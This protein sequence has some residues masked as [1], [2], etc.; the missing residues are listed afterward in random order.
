M[1]L[2]FHTATEAAMKDRR[3]AAIALTRSGISLARR[4]GDMLEGLDIYAMPSLCSEPEKPIDRPIAELTGEIL[5][6]Y[7]TLIFITA[8]GIAVRAIAPHIR[9]K[10]SDPAV[11]VMD[12]Q[13]SFVIS[14]LSGHLGGANDEA[15]LVESLTGAKAVI[16]TASDVGGRMAVDTLAKRLGCEIDCLEDAKRITALMVNGEKVAIDCRHSMDMDIP[17][18]MV[19]YGETCD[20]A[21]IIRITNRIPK[22][23]ELPCAHLIEKTTVIGLGCRRGTCAKAI[24]NIIDEELER[25]GIDNRSI[26]K[27]ASIDIKRDEAGILEA[28]ENYGSQAC[29]IAKERILAV[30][31]DFAESGFVRASVGVGGVCEP[32][33]FIASGGGSMLLGKTARCGV[34]IS[35]WEEV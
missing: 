4:L 26:K 17:E 34:A 20:A 33:G 27:L 25:L 12:E 16:T 11:L 19:Q 18:G 10:R 35:V 30:E 29:F 24:Q 32:C 7:E 14:L 28:A 2:R 9:S 22:P 13:G 3:R 5:G 31:G 21:G 15:R 1:T 23:A 8:C 6:K